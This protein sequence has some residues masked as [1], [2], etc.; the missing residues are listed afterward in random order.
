MS[1]I[2]IL[3][4]DDE[5]TICDSLKLKINRLKHPFEY[6][7]RSCTSGNEALRL[8]KTEQFDMMITDIRMPFMS[9]LTLVKEV[10]DIGFTGTILAL[11]GYDD[12]EYVREAF[13]SG[14]DDYLLKPIASQILDRKLL[15]YMVVESQDE[16]LADY[17]DQGIRKPATTIEY[18]VEY[19]ENHYMNSSLSMDEVAK[20]VHL[21]YSYFSSLFKHETGLTFPAYLREHR[22]KKAI[23]YLSDPSI[24]I[25]DI[26]TSVGFKYPQQFSQDFKRVM[27]FY[28]SE[29][30]NRIN[31]SK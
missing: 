26:S 17:D 13:L 14:V 23:E 18:A 6:V 5:V 15:Q 28:P 27:G 25:S 30:V 21:S 4:V 29:Y 8:I 16:T 10:R 12:F 7:T 2:S 20:H 11:S 24:K 3:I 9:G 31:E 19:I 1:K 22:I